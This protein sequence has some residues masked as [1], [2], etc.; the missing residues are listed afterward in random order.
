M[1]Q[2]RAPLRQAP[3]VER[4][5]V[6]AATVQ[7][8]AAIAPVHS[9]IQGLQQR[10]V[11]GVFSTA[12]RSAVGTAPVSVAVPVS[13]QCVRIST[14]ND[15]AELEAVRIA[16]KVIQMGAPTEPPGVKAGE[17]KQKP[18][19]QRAAASRWRRAAVGACRDRSRR[20]RR[21]SRP[22]VRSF[23][24]PRFGAN[25]GNVR[26]HTGEAAAQQS[27]SARTP[28]PSPS[29]SSLLRPR[30][31]PAA[32]APAG[33]EL[34]AHE[35]THTIQ[36]GAAVQRSVTTPAVIA[37]QRSRRSSASASATRSTTSP[38]RPTSSRASGCSRSCSA[39]TRSTW[40]RSSAAPPTS[41]ARWSS[42]FR[43]PA[44]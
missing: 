44:R 34:I 23:M 15:P 28:T 33:S 12:S 29:A 20:R 24:E 18:L 35:L 13:I 41:C 22:P 43:S 8:N 5:P 38:T 36:Q 6:V 16:R 31:V 7:R 10:G 11:R 30:Q 4:R 19:V 42:S 25:F 40:R 32:R 2:D 21:R 26:I 39:S 3:A 9:P 27:A 17:A 37:A 1:A 14:P